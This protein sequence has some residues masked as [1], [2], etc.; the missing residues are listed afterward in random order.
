MGGTGLEPVTPS[1]S[2]RSM[3]FASFPFISP[4]CAGSRTVHANQE[5]EEL[6]RSGHFSTIWGGFEHQIG[7]A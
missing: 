7:T 1:L 2:I 5:L 4:G 6:G 3:G